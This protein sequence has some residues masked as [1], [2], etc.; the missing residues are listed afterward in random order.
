MCVVTKKRESNEKTPSEDT[1]EFEK[2]LSF[3]ESSEEHKDE[4]DSSLNRIIFNNEESN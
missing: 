2:M 3:E 4:I 1:D